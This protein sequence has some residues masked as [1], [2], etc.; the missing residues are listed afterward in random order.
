VNSLSLQGTANGRGGGAATAFLNKPEPLPTEPDRI[1]S[2]FLL[3]IAVVPDTATTVLAFVLL[4]LI[5]LSFILSGSEV[6][7]FSLRFKE[8]NLMKTKQRPS[9][10]RLLRLLEQPRLLLASLAIADVFVNILIIVVGDQTVDALLADGVLH[11]MA[12]LAVKVVVISLL[13]LVFGE[14]LPR[15]WAGHQPYRFSFFSSG[16]A[17]VL[18][19]VFK[20]VAARLLTFSSGIHRAMGADD[21]H[22]YTLEQL[23]QAIHLSD[24]GYTSEEERNMLKGIV[25]FGNTNVRQIMRSRL[26]VHGVDVE[27]GFAEL[28]SR[29]EE[30]HYSRLPVYKGSLD[31]IVGIVHTKDLIPH[32]SQP[33]DFHWQSLIRP[34]YYVHENKPIEDLLQEFQSKRTHF[35]VVVDEFGGTEGIVTLEDI[36]EEVIGD[37]RDEFDDEEV[38]F[39]RID[40]GRFTM[41]G[42]VPIAEACRLM[43]LPADVFKDVQGDSETMAGLLMELAGEIPSADR[44]IRSGDFLFKVLEV[45]KNR[46]R[47]ISV[48]IESLP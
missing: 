16:I 5:F 46:I 2:L 14:M 11:P 41:D 31:R 36:L 48:T 7:I 23:D 28:V 19:R 29:V 13:L 42:G 34:P 30:L 12:L 22:E 26:D 32:L 4:G 35:A 45:E 37:I 10:K 39:N 40:E 20:G 25:K 43:G 21:G 9:E 47:K 44:E 27:A 18:H 38:R 24:T 17:S 8:I 33:A 15:I 3:P 6:G 1:P